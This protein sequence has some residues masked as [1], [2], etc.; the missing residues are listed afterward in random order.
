MQ[1]KSILFSLWSAA[2]HWVLVHSIT[3]SRMDE[4]YLGCFRHIQVVLVDIKKHLFLCLCLHMS[5]SETAQVL[6]RKATIPCSSI[7]PHSYSHKCSLT[8]GDLNDDERARFSAVTSL[9][10]SAV[11]WNKK[12]SNKQQ[13]NTLWDII[14]GALLDCHSSATSRYLLQICV[15]FR[16][17]LFPLGS[18][19]Y[20]IMISQAKTMVI[21]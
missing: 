12:Q 2:I 13:R 20:L 3:W 9:F 14:S 8:N 1:P 19:F 6:Q 5:L 10:T 11:E 16:F 7:C 21:H 15:H 17:L 18:T 4:Q